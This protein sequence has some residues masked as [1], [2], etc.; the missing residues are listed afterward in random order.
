MKLVCIG[1]KCAQE[2]GCPLVDRPPSPEA[3]DAV[4]AR[5][6]PAVESVVVRT[7]QRSEIY[8]AA[9][10]D[11]GAAALA[12]WITAASRAL[13]E[14][15]ATPYVHWGPEC[16]THL[17]RVAAGID[18][19]VLGESEILAQLRLA[20][21]HARELGQSR[22]LLGR[23]FSRAFRVGRRARAETSIAF[24]SVSL[25]NAGL[26]LAQRELGGLEGRAAL[27]IGAG[28]IAERAVSCL[29]R[30]G[31]ALRI[32]N[33]TQS[34]AQQLAVRYGGTA[35][36]FADA[37]A[38]ACGSDLVVVAIRAPRALL[39]ADLLAAFTGARKRVIVD[40]G[41]PPCVDADVGA[42]PDRVLFTLAD[43]QRE[44]NGSL[45]ARRDAVPAVEAIVREETNALL[46][47]REAAWFTRRAG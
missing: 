4:A 30:R 1:A 17:F 46:T 22:K 38:I 3:W 32:A 27:V 19:V 7:C 2:T 28:M 33:R 45:V 21:H 36:P 15:G 8:A 12:E 16:V 18:S 20:D 9:P 40:F 39:R 29:V 25:A 26:L 31:A 47:Q 10:S 34:R 35:L 11:A 37:P 43:A 42:L 24:G 41:S 14:S 6:P 44:A 5:V 13:G 23:L